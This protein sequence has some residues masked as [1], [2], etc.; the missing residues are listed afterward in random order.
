[1]RTVL[2]AQDNVDIRWTIKYAFMKR[3]YI[4]FETGKGNHV[5]E[6]VQTLRPDLVVLDTNH[7]TL[8]AKKGS[9]N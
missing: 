2:I 4:A 9:S 6:M 1:M 3:G 7:P 8:Y 5:L